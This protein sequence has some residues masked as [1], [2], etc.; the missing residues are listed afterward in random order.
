VK[1]KLIRF[2]L[3]NPGSSFTLPTLQ[4]RVQAPLGAVRKELVGLER[5]GVLRKRTA[6]TAVGVKGNRKKRMPHWYLD[7]AFP[8]TDALHAFFT[9]T[10]ELSDKHLVNKI[11]KTGKI[12]LIVVTGV[13][14]K[15]WENRIDILIVGDEVRQG[16]LTRAMKTIEA[17][18]GRELRVAFLTTSD[19][20][21]RIGVYDKLIRD[22]LD[23]SHKVLLDK[24][25]LPENIRPHSLST[26]LGVPF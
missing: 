10:T 21:Y 13:F 8:Y 9:S 15:N 3:F 7:P 17:D 24:V 19:F 16:S 25:G 20:K 22:V 12:K 5:G 14:V 18:M 26:S 23:Y 11:T 1:T 2:F 4:D 6:M